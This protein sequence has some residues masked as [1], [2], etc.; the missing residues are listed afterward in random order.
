MLVYLNGR[1]V[2]KAE[3]LI[4]P[5]DRGFLFADGVYEVIRGVRGRLFEEEAH[6]ARMANGIRAL[7][8]PLP[9]GGLESLA[10]AARELLVRNGLMEGEST[11]YLQLTRGVAPRSHAY[12]PAGTSATVYAFASRFQPPIAIQD[13]GA[14]AITHEDI[15]WARC[16]LK[17]INLLANSWAKQAAIEAGAFEAIFVRDGRVTDGA[18][19]NVFAV[20]DGALCTPPLSHF[21][22]PGITREVVI[23]LAHAA[24]LDVREQEMTAAELSGADELF[25]TGTTTDVTPIVRLDGQTICGGVPGRVS[26]LLQHALR[27]RLDACGAGLAI[28]LDDS[29]VVTTHGASAP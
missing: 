10:G 5:D 7:S 15:R 25:I 24:R 9:P 19:S 2:D 27:H 3:A 8:L 28:P 22:L 26:R 14:A 17:T 23:A 6:F 16:D 13:A 18:S 21:M 20:L 4:S 1:F 11:I 29:G 12:P